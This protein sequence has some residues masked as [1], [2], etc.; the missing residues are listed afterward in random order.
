ETI[1]LKASDK[2]PR[3][4]YQTAE[5][6]AEDLQCFVE[7]RPI[8]ARRVGELERLWSWCR[9]N[10]A[11][12]GMAAAVLLLVL[13][14]AIGSTVAAVWLGRALRDTGWANTVANA[15]LWDSLLVQARA[16]R[17]S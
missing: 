6:L 16:T 2:D 17:K 13:T 4:R 11:L 12:A 9:R 5:A 7:G 10:R 1:V 15:R 14:V 3:R 8:K